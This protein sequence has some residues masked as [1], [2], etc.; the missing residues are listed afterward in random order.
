VADFLHPAVFLAA[1]LDWLETLLPVLFVMIWI[2][3]QVA[4]VIR[5]VAGGG[6]KPAAERRPPPLPAGRGPANDPQA[7]ELRREIEVFLQKVDRGA[8]T[9]GP[10]PVEAEGRRDS[11]AERRRPRKPKQKPTPPPI[12]AAAAGLSR[13]LPHLVSS[14]TAR[15]GS[16]SERPPATSAATPAAAIARLL[17][18]PAGIRQAIVLNEVLERPLSR[19]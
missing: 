6:A 9:V 15:Q 2:V 7:E 5:K 4:G 18:D 3:S 14:L 11:S 16:E 17:A 13:E 8:R 12:P 1:G 19:W 10:T